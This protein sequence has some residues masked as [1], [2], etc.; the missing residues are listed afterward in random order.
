[1]ILITVIG[2]CI[3][4]VKSEEPVEVVIL[5]HDVKVVDRVEADYGYTEDQLEAEIYEFK[6]HEIDNE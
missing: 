6:L 4:N 2:G 5:D 3:V 1:M